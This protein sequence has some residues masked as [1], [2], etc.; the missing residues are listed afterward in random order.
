[1]HKARAFFFVCA[2]ISLLALSYHLGA[3]SAGAQ[4]G[5]SIEAANF[6]TGAYGS[7]NTVSFVVNRVLYTSYQ[8]PTGLQ[9]QIPASSSAGTVPGAAPVGA[10]Y[11][12][13]SVG[14]CCGQD[15]TGSQEV[16]GSIP[17][18]STILT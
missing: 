9:W 10:T 4:S 12:L 15:P 13:C 7:T 16:V 17:S 3:R 11:S 2:G 5:G 18:S 8:L 14:I 6:T 1:M